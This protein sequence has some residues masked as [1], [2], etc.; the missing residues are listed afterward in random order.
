M[1][2]ARFYSACT[3]VA[4]KFLPR[5]P[6]KIQTKKLVFLCPF[7]STSN[8]INNDFNPFH[9]STT[10]KKQLHRGTTWLHIIKFFIRKRQNKANY[11]FHTLITKTRRFHTRFLSQA[12]KTLK[13]RAVPE[14]HL[15][16][17]RH[18]LICDVTLRCEPTP[19]QFESS[20]HQAV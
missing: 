6:L 11:W 2:F 15:V 13:K 17:A 9:D 19:D 8:R 3:S 12:E 20:R 5:K 4:E 18:P 7:G 1:Y 10:L 14:A 16:S